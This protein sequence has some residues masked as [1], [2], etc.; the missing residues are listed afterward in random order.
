VA[1]AF[2]Y[3]NVG[4]VLPNVFTDGTKNVDAVLVKNFSVN[5]SDRKITAQFRSEFYNVFNHPLFASPNGTVTSQS[6][7]TITAQGNNP[8]DIQFGLKIVF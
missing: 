6:F 4:P 5:I 3:G 1:P 7:G 2:T 8:R